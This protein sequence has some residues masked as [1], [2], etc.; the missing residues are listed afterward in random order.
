MQFLTLEVNYKILLVFV[1]SAI[2]EGYPDFQENI[3]K[4]QKFTLV[5]W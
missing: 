5:L 3:Y 1:I 2:L 4:I